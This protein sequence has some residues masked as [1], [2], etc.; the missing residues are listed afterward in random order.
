MDWKEHY[1]RRL[2]S[3]DEAVNTVESGDLVYIAIHP[4][5]KALI[6]ALAD[7]REELRGVE[8][9]QDAPTFGP[10]VVSI[11][12]SGLI[13]DGSG[14]DMGWCTERHRPISPHEGTK[15]ALRF[16]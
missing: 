12:M 3:A 2:V 4:Q 6:Y 15:F 1:K 8:V 13:L 16:R 5:P 7:R 14:D 9:W 11:R 10:G